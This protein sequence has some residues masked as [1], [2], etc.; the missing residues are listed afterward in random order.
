MYF[1]FLNILQVNNYLKHA[2]IDR[3][4]EYG[5]QSIKQFKEWLGK[6]NEISNMHSTL[7]KEQECH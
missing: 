3:F 6:L 4:T 7:R 5:A 1:T 2:N